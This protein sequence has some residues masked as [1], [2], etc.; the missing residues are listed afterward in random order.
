MSYDRNRIINVSIPNRICAKAGNQEAVP[1]LRLF[2][3]PA[4]WAC[5]LAHACEMNCF[6]VLLS[7]LPTYFHETFP[8]AQ[9]WIVNMIPW[10][11]LPPCTFIA[12]LINDYLMTKGWSLSRIR[13]FSQSC[14]FIGQNI[15]L[16]IMC[17]TTNFNVTLICM[18]FI[19][20][21]YIFIIQF[22]NQITF[23][24]K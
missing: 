3:K 18:T 14:C 8:L 2:I 12:K 11:A 15:S 22:K 6:F 21:N 5:A 17:R 7:W 10:M 16:F 19:I 20:G 1:W 24:I 23:C 4:F 9:G 13:K